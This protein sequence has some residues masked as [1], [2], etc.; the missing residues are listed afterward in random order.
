MSWTPAT[1][2]RPRA[3]HLSRMPILSKHRESTDLFRCYCEGFD[4]AGKD[5]SPRYV[6]LLTCRSTPLSLFFS[7]FAN[8]LRADRGDS[9]TLFCKRKCV[10][11]AQF[12][13]NVSPLDA[14]LLGPL[15]CV[16]S[17]GLT[18][19]QNCAEWTHFRLQKRVLESPRSAR[20]RFA[21]GLKKRLRGVERQVR[22]RTYLGEGSFPARSKP[23]Q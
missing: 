18:L 5:P 14:T 1:S 6:R 3:A 15:V 22:R 2:I 8:R 21:K 13:R 23:S 9:R 12:W 17:K 4:L 19:R 7:P 20:R 11:S 10:H 16:A